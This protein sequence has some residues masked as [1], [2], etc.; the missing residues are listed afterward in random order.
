MDLVCSCGQHIKNTEVWILKDIKNFDSRKLIIG[1]CNCNKLK[2]ALVERRLSDKQIFT[3]IIDDKNTSKVLLKEKN[4]LVCRYYDVKSSS[5]YGWIY[6]VNIEIKNKQGKV[7]QIR[8]YSADFNGNKE[9]QRK[10]KV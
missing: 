6:G 10:M 7:T 5:L 8:Q 2:L 1:Y 4:R 3:N 9:I